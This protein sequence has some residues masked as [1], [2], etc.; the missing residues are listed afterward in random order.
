[1]VELEVAEMVVE[2]IFHVDCTAAWVE[3]MGADTNT[4][5]PAKLPAFEKRRRTACAGRLTARD[6]ARYNRTNIAIFGL[7]RASG[8]CV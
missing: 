7:G 5:D 8:E 4:P 1:M 2:H 3:I 6:R